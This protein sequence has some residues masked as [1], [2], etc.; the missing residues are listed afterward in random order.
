MSV[1]N[2]HRERGFL[3]DEPIAFSSADVPPG[4]LFVPLGFEG[5]VESLLSDD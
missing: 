2:F 4:R 3:G 1:S 5:F